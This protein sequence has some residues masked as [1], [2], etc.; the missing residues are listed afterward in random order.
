MPHA[1]V[2]SVLL[3]LCVWT[4]S[5]AYADDDRLRQALALQQ[6]GQWSLAIQAI[7]TLDV[8]DTPAPALGRLLYLRGKLALQLQNTEAAL[9]DF[10]QVL[11]TY[12]PLG[13]YAGWEMLQ[14]YAAQDEVGKLYDTFVV[15][16]RRYPFSRLLPDSYILLAQVLLRQAQHAQAQVILEQFLRTYDSTHRL[17]P[18]AL[19]LLAQS[20]ADTGQTARAAQTWQRL[21]ESHPTHTLASGSLAA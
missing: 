19:S 18:E 14:Y 11:Y 4:Q 20:Y 16:T 8:T 21:G 13:D 17:A 9:H 7:G 2:M 5:L 3:A 6:A 10:A 12:P 1:C 15:L